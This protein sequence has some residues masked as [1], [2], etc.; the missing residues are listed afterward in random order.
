MN[1]LYIGSCAAQPDFQNPRALGTSK[2]VSFTGTVNTFCLICEWAFKFKVRSTSLFRRLH[3]FHKAARHHISFSEAGKRRKLWI[4]GCVAS[5][6]EARPFGRRYLPLPWYLRTGVSLSVLLS[7]RVLGPNGDF[8]SFQSDCRL[9]LQ[10]LLVP[11]YRKTLRLR[12]GAQAPTEC[13]SGSCQPQI[14]SDS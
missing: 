2:F 12:L 10:A 11:L 14:L 1:S 4:R 9:S 7:E 3:K 6:C 5:F 13:R 8:T